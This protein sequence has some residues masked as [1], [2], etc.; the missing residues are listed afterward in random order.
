[1]IDG[2]RRKAKGLLDETTKK[3]EKVKSGI[4]QANK[5]IEAAERWVGLCFFLSF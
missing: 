3:L 5:D 4:Y 1:M 2:P